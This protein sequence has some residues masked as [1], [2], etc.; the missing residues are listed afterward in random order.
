VTRGVGYERVGVTRE[1]ELDIR[2]IGDAE[3]KPDA[4]E[5]DTVPE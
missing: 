2:R 5:E 4:S 1:G 3:P